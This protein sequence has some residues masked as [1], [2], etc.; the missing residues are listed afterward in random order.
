MSSTSTGEQFNGIRR[1]PFLEDVDATMKSEKFGKTAEE[2]LRVLDRMYS[3]YKLIEA[4][5]ESQRQKY[6]VEEMVGGDG[7][8]EMVERKTWRKG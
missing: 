7:G 4:T 5:L 3:N 6:G 1:A 8:E 2:A